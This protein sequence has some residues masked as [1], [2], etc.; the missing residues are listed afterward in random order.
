MA[1]RDIMQEIEEL[2]KQL[3]ALE[4]VK[5]HAGATV[6]PEEPEQGPRE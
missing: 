4:A 2:K 3:Q 1:D 6:S 5:G